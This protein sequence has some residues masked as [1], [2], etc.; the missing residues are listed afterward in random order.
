MS[1]KNKT[2]MYISF[3]DE[4]AGFIEE[5][6]MAE[7]CTKSKFVYRLIR[8]EYESYRKKKISEIIGGGKSM[9]DVD[10]D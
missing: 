8:K 10:L 9:I 1:L 7:S 4:V 6:A 2:R 3:D 5:R